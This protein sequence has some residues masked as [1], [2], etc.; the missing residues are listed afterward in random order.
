MNNK[1][2]TKGSKK[3]A[4]CKKNGKIFGDFDKIV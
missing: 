1:K 2:V 4:K 3:A